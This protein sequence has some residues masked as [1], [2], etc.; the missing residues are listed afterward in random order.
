MSNQ[1]ANSSTTARVQIRPQTIREAYDPPANVLEVDVINPETHGVANKRFTD[2][3]VRLRVST[4]N[5]NMHREYLLVSHF[6]LISK[7]KSTHGVNN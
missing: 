7:L 2:Y 6:K 4:T 5:K 1:V 3:E